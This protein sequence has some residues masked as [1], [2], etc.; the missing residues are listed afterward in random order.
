MAS[1]FKRGGKQNKGGYYYVSWFDH[2]G[3][4]RSK[5]AKT[6]DKATAERI[7]AKFETDAAKRREGL[8]DPAAETLA[9]ELKRPIAELVGEYKAKLTATGRSERYI[10]DAVGYVER[11]IAASAI[12]TPREITAQA[13]EQFAVKL[14]DDGRSARTIQAAL[15]A[16]KSFTR[17]LV[18]TGKLHR[19]PLASVKK[20]N[21]EADRK[22]RRRMLLP[23]EWPHLQSATEDGPVRHGMTGPDRT[24]LYRLATQTGLRANELRSLTRES[25]VLKA[26]KPYV[27]VRAGDTKNRKMAQQFV[28]AELAAAL[29]QHVARK[30]PSAKLFSMPDRTKLAKMLRADL[31]AARTA[32]IENAKG[33]PEEL[34]K[35]QQSDFLAAGN[36]AGESFDFHSLRHTCGAW[37]A[38]NGAQLKTVQAV[39]RHSTI[40]LTMGTYGHLFPGAEAEAADN[41][42]RMFTPPA[43][44]LDTLRMTG[45]DD[46]P[47]P[48]GS[49]Q[50]Q[51]QQLAQQTGR[52]G[53][54]DSAVCDDEHPDS[55]RERQGTKTLSFPASKRPAAKRHDEKRERRARDSNPQPVARHLNSNRKITLRCPSLALQS[56]V[57]PG[58]F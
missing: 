13:V 28:G 43:D 41:L 57:F 39:L 18:T 27:L 24:L 25:V 9:N 5:C 53:L 4:R 6:T 45:T 42:G 21:P 20:P 23:E 55:N 37:M 52:D 51:A 3:K 50:R 56:A 49:A 36:H 14:G 33:D 31:A 7:G 44:S 35:R 34:I 46:R 26:T 11:I 17:W 2:F 8:T 19:D 38:L 58:V 40:N 29:K 1:T 12:A 16:V 54:H 10:A 48:R 30:T 22:R 32:W 15:G 47:E